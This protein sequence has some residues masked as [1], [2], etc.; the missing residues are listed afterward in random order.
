MKRQ[1][2]T[3]EERTAREAE[4]KRQAQEIAAA[5]DFDPAKELA[6]LRERIATLEGALSIKTQFLRSRQCPDHS[7]KWDRGRCLQCE[8]EEANR[9]IATL[10]RR[11][12][13]HDTVNRDQAE[14]YAKRIAMLEAENERLEMASDAASE[15]AVHE[16]QAAQAAQATLDAIGKC[17]RYGM[18]YRGADDFDLSPYPD[19]EWLKASDIE[20]IIAKAKS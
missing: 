6:Y 5:A 8:L 3:G 12:R 14:S 17:P 1:W 16:H 7:G 20:R 2:E 15:S 10:E 4:T 19:G 9:S 18:G 13:M 11:N